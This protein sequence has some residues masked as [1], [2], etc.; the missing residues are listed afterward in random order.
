MSARATAPISTGGAVLA[1]IP[2]RASRLGGG[3]TARTTQA[4]DERWPTA[5]KLTEAGHDRALG[6]LPTAR[7]AARADKHKKE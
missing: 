2:L 3:A 6:S 7:H 4:R 1:I 5:R